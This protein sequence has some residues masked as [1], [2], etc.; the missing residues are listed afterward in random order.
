MPTYLE[1]L[2]IRLGQGMESVP[3]E[4]RWRHGRWLLAQQQ[5]D[6]GFGGRHPGS[7]LYYTSFALRALALVDG[8]AGP[9]TGHAEGFLRAKLTSQETIVDF[10]SLLYSGFLLKTAAGRD[11]FDGLPEGW[12]KRVADWLE[13]L[14]SSDGGYRKS[15]LGQAGSTYHS[16]LVLLCYELLEQPVPDPEKLISFLLNHRS[17]DGGFLEIT[18]AKRAGTNPTAAAVAALRML[19]ALDDEVCQDAVDFLSSMQ[20]DEGGFCANSRI[21]LP[22]LLSTFTGLWTLADLHALD[23]ID[24]D[25]T[26]RFVEQLESPEGGFLAATIDEQ[27]DVEYTFYGLGCLALLQ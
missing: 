24:L 20:S 26:R 17:P 19:G 21:V 6:G 4:R 10:F 14:R 3:E 25:R 9:Q 22:D 12:Q 16:F 13:T 7:D 2:L 18:A 27:R 11:I 5:P 15:P 1:R 8:L 23:T